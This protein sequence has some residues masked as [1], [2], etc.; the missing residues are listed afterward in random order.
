MAIN[1]TFTTFSQ[2][3]SA[4]YPDL[5][6]LPNKFWLVGYDAENYRELRFDIATT[7]NPIITCVLSSYTTIT[8]LSSELEDS[9]DDLEEELRTS[10]N[11]LSS[12]ITSPDLKYTNETPMPV[13]FTPADGIVRFKK[14][15][16]FNNMLIKDIITQLLYPAIN[17]S[18]TLSNTPTL[19]KAGTTTSKTI[20]VNLTEGTTVTQGADRT[21]N[22]TGTGWKQSS[23][24]NKLTTVSN[25]LTI[26]PTTETQTTFN[27]SVT[28]SGEEK[29][30]K[31]FTVESVFPIYATT[32]NSTTYTEQKLSSKN[33][34]VTLTLAAETAT[35]YY[36]VDIPNSWNN[37]SKIDVLNPVTN[38]FE[39]W[40]N[41]R[42]EF[43]QSTTTHNSVSYKRYARTG[44]PTG[45]IIGSNTFKLTF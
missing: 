24:T 40:Q 21:Y 41:W 10:F 35:T 31:S 1:Y 39:E 26:L 23:I 5:A 9:F 22:F 36:T 2:F 33:K 30:S 43:K 11:E 34:Q 16:T 29:T 7:L 27:V 18:I 8:T 20:T 14:G 45:E 4:K 28:Q 38:K 3:A 32:V 12:E 44:K 19:I 25:T 17:A 6:E 13:D 42:T 37:I 15:T